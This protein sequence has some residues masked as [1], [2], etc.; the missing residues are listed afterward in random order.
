MSVQTKDTIDAL[1]RDGSPSDLLENANEGRVTLAMGAVQN[2]NLLN[3]S[4]PDGR[5]EAE[6]WSTHR[7]ELDWW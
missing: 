2:E 3:E 1:T 7:L 6:P 5:L 4:L